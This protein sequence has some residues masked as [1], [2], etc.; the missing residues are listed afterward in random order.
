[1][2]RISF[3]CWWIHPMPVLAFQYS[4][5]FTVQHIHPISTLH[6][7]SLGSQIVDLVNTLVC[8]MRS[9]LWFSVCSLGWYLHSMI[10][11]PFNFLSDKLNILT[12]EPFI[13]W[14][15]LQY[16]Y[17]SQDPSLITL[18]CINLFLELWA[19]KCGHRL[20]VDSSEYR[21]NACGLLLL[22]VAHLSIQDHL[23]SFGHS[24]AQQGTGSWLGA[25][26]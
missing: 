4:I 18:Q 9:P 20:S 12:S 8:Y 25:E 10:G 15:S 1:M 26:M 11:S 23:S 21:G 14:H 7:S 2:S 16:F 17:H 5:T 6:L 24:F 19:P 22:S 3:H 13:S